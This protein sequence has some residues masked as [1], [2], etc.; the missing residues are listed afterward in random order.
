MLQYYSR[1]RPDAVRTG[2]LFHS[3]CKGFNGMS[4]EH[5]PGTRRTLQVFRCHRD[6]EMHEDQPREALEQAWPYPTVV[7]QFASRKE[8][9]NH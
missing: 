1:S 8:P 5:F 4:V 9:G 3:M 6:L 2:Q 7:S